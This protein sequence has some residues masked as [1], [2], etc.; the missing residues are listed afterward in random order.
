MLLHL[1][2]YATVILCSAL[3]HGYVRPIEEKR[4]K[5]TTHSNEDRRR[6]PNSLMVTNISLIVRNISLMV[7]ISLAVTNICPMVTDISLMMTNMSCTH[8]QSH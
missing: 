7:T 5:S 4:W 8:I 6:P 1:Q 2:M 3:E